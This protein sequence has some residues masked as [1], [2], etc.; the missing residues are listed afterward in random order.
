M[1]ENFKAVEISDATGVS[2]YTEVELNTSTTHNSQSEIAV[3]I[4]STLPYFI[5]TGQANYWTGSVTA[6]F[7][8]NKT[9]PCPNEDYGEYDF[10]NSHFRFEFV[11]W[12]HNGYPKTLKLAN[13]FI[14]LV[15]IGNQIQLQSDST[16]DDESCKVSFEW[17][18]IGARYSTT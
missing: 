3:P 12:M 1:S 6:D 13:D 7:A 17:T 10:T 11:E 8:D 5:Q 18:Q 4:N 15:G 2:Y 16:I 9:N 14:M